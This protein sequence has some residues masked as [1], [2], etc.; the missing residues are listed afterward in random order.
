MKKNKEAAVIQESHRQV[1][2]SWKDSYEIFCSRRTTN[3]VNPNDT[4]VLDGLISG[5][6]E[7][8]TELVLSSIHWRL[9]LLVIYFVKVRVC[10]NTNSAEEIA[11]YFIT[12]GLVSSHQ[13]N[14]LVD[15]VLKWVQAG[16]NYEDLSRNIGGYGSLVFLPDIGRSKY[17]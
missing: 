13:F 5:I 11:R 12:N 14:Y 10:E 2:W 8:D 3:I 15:N 16:A 4:L 1:I 6:K 7:D 9:S 17:V